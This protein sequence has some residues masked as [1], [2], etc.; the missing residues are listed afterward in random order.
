[1]QIQS[2]FESPK[3]EDENCHA[4]AIL[5]QKRHD[6]LHGTTEYAP[7][8]VL[9]TLLHCHSSLFAE[10]RVELSTAVAQRIALYLASLQRRVGNPIDLSCTDDKPVTVC[11]TVYRHLDVLDDARCC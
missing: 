6:M 2:P 8:I 1:M 5:A 9:P 11:N 10:Q 3:A 4:R 7:K